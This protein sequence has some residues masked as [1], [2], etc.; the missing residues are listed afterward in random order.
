MKKI[1][2]ICIAFLYASFC[3]GQAAN[4]IIITP[5][6]GVGKLKLGM[7]K[8]QA[9]DI[10][11]GEITWGTYEEQ[12]Q[13]FVSY[14]AR[15]DSVVQFIQ[16]FDECGRYNSEL[17]VSMPVFALYFKNNKLNFITISSYSATEDQLKL[18]KLNNGLK[19]FATQEDCRKKMGTEYLNV[20]YDDYTGDHYYY[21]KGIEMVYDNEELRSIG[22]FPPLPKFKEMIAAK[23][24][25]LLQ[26]AEKYKNKTDEE[27]EEEN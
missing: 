19:Y 21:K 20:L 14:D 13:S 3:I 8:K 25:K 26:E 23:S 24:E 4:P 16:G 1:A 18:V 5:G 11:K 2:I 27:E 9:T 15:V 7:T 10:L 12:L 6:V 17:P 22:I